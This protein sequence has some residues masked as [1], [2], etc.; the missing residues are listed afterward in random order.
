MRTRIEEADDEEIERLVLVV[1][2]VAEIPK[3]LRSETTVVRQ[4]SG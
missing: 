2:D 4:R 1:D 3:T